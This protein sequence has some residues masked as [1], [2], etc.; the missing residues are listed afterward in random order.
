MITVKTKSVS[1]GN[2]K[3]RIAAKS[4]I[5]RRYWEEQPLHMRRLKRKQVNKNEVKNG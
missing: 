5:A 1:G 4:E 3:M 2:E